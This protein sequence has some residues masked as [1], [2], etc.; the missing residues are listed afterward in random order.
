MMLELQKKIQAQD[1]QIDALIAHGNII[2][3]RNAQ[4]TSSL[5]EWSP[6]V[7]PCQPENKECHEIANA[8]HHRSGV[9]SEEP[10]LQTE[11]FTDFVDYSV[12]EVV[13]DGVSWE[14]PI[15]GEKGVEIS[16]QNI[17]FPF[18]SHEIRKDD[19]CVQ[20]DYIVNNLMPQTLNR[21][22]LEAVFPDGSFAG[23]SDTWEE[24]VDV[25]P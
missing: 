20:I 13:R 23:I 1:S 14:A 4:L 12:D 11:E 24:E 18:P 2:D 9:S 21:D 7:L 25:M 22:S 19:H 10:P 8:V 3:T 17:I 6:E 5:A 16:T 15:E